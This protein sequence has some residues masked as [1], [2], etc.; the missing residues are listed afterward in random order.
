M[1]A[2][3][4]LSLVY[5]IS[6]KEQQQD[7]KD[8]RH[9]QQAKDCQPK[10][11]HRPVGS[12]QHAKY[13]LMVSDEQNHGRCDQVISIMTAR[14]EPTHDHFAHLGQTHRSPT[15]NTASRSIHQEPNNPCF[16][17]RA[18]S[19]NRTM[20]TTPPAI[21]TLTIHAINSKSNY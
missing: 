14:V 11:G 3:E 6:R 9:I 5:H 8:D 1:T 18:T 2:L 21:S 16:R 12:H 10:H 17:K 4:Q 19:E 7:E 20:H 15:T 13:A